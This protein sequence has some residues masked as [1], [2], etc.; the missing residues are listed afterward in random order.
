MKGRLGATAAMISSAVI[1]VTLGEARWG[2][3][4]MQASQPTHRS[5]AQRTRPASRDRTP[6]GQTET[7]APQ[8]LHRFWVSGL[9]Q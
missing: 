4:R 6:A 1:T 2:Q 5:A 3:Q 8:P 7:Q 9:W